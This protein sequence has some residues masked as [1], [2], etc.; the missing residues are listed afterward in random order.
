MLSYFP[1]FLQTPSL[2][3]GMAMLKHRAVL[4]NLCCLQVAM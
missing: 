1:S 2:L 3:V 4:D